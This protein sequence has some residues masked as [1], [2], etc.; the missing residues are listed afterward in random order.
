[1]LVLMLVSVLLVVV[2]LLFRLP[3]YVRQYAGLGLPAAMKA[4]MPL[5][6]YPIYN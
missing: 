3:E 4:R 6:C 5:R 2:R 1:M